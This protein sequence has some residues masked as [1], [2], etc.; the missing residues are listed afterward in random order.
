[1]D[2]FE[3]I[4]SITIVP[5][6]RGAT[7]DN[8]I[9]IG[10]ALQQ[11]GIPIMEITMETRGA[12]YALEKAV[13][14]LEG[15]VVGAGTVIDSETAQRV[16]EAGAQFI[17]SPTFSVDVIQIAKKRKIFSVAGGLTPTEIVAAFQCGA[18]MIKVFPASTF[19]PKYIQ[20]IKEP[21]PHIPLMVT[22]GINEET[23]CKYIKAGVD[24]V[25]IGNSLVNT[26][27]LLNDR[28]LQEITRRALTLTTITRKGYTL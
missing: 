8:I 22:G 15:M 27:R 26:R 11:G 28:E 9:P 13:L 14:E 20:Q 2:L 5:V 6:I 17:V 18:D 24:A 12:L 19:G 4:R 25:G 1:M 23:I 3:F 16:I 10:L 7:V 21:L